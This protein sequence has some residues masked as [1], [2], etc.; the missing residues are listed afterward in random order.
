MKHAWYGCLLCLSIALA[1][2]EDPKKE[3]EKEEVEE[4]EAGNQ[5]D[6]VIETMQDIITNVDKESEREAKAL[7]GFKEWCKKETES[8]TESTKKAKE[9][10]EKAFV[11]IRDETAAVAALEFAEN[12]LKNQAKELQDTLDQMTNIYEE[13]TAKYNEEAELNSASARTVGKALTH[14][15]S[16]K[17]SA[18]LQQRSASSSPDYVIGVMKG[19]KENLAKTRKELDADQATRKKQHTDLSAKKRAQMATVQDEIAAKGKLLSASKLKLVEAQSVYDSEQGSDV[20][21][22]QTADDAVKLCK[23]KEL[24]F[25]IRTKDRAE[26]K[27]QLKQ[28]IDTLKAA[29]GKKD[30][31]KKDAE[32]KKTA[33]FLQVV[34]KHDH[35]AEAKEE[36][37]RRFR[38]AKKEA[39]LIMQQTK[40][41]G[42]GLDQAAEAVQKLMEAIKKTQKEDAKRRDFCKSQKS[43][44]EGNK[45]IADGQVVRLKSRIGFLESEIKELKTEAEALG[46]DAKGFEDKLKNLQKVRFEEKAA[47]QE[48]H[49]ERELTM[50]VLEKAKSIVSNFYEST[51]QTKSEFFQV[52]A[53]PS[54]PPALWNPGS[55]RQEDL[56]NAVVQL[57][58]GL[59]VGF[60]K[61][62]KDADEEFEKDQSESADL[63]KDSQAVFDRKKTQES[64]LLQRVASNSVELA[65]VKADAES[66]EKAST[67]AEELLKKLDKDCTDLLTNYDAT[68]KERQN[69]LY[70]LQDV[71]EILGGAS[72]GSNG[73]KSG[74]LQLKALK[75]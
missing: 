52:D 20:E 28:T 22:Q 46:D 60:E 48:A 50:K 55:S 37:L 29:V 42:E 68:Y 54:K 61:E 65:Q 34:S 9:Q 67:S 69:Q 26:E 51:D 39:K 31:E 53:E 36:K 57:L 59:I 14:L 40:S 74:L 43:V 38:A 47:Y 30:E 5:F 73:L 75:A 6:L 35:A 45:I 58:E 64:A 11:T 15:E 41:K 56:G 23:K 13:E 72:L 4:V 10:V 16:Q 18:F 44:E 24:E 8:L 1:L 27:K 21:M 25:D 70:G 19:I 49:K 3:D 33:F 2:A 17:N 66:S 71:A 12:K 62:Q 7:K 32:E 63:E